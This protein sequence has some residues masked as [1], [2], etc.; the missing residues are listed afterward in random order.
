MEGQ[1]VLSASEHY[2]EIDNYLKENKIKK[3]FLVCGNS[4]NSLRIYDYLKKLEERMG[5][6]YVR[7]SNF[8]PNPAYESVLEGVKLFCEEGCDLIMAVGGGSAIDVAK[9]IKLYSNM[10]QSVSFLEQK[11]SPNDVKLFAVPTTAGSGSEATRYAVI[12]SNGEKQ[13]IT[14]YSCVP[15]VVLLDPSVLRTLPEYQKKAAML[16]A[17]CHAIESF[18]SV[19]ATEESKYYAKQAL[20]LILK[21][22]DAYLKNEVSGNAGMLQAANL[23]GMAINITQ[24]TAGHAM[25]YKLTGLYG[26]AHGHAAALCV[27]KLWSYM[28]DATNQYHDLAERVCLQKVFLEIAQA[29]GCNTAKAA[30]VQFQNILSELELAIPDSKEEDYAILRESV[31]MT[32]LRN[33]PM[34]LNAEVIE[35]L[36]RQILKK[37]DFY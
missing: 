36:Y 25:C 8:K 34:E 7:Y 23:A 24:T 21:Y 32:R 16:D 35:N 30:A 14:D 4:I 13:S 27:A 9:C 20:R 12:Y 11:I 28:I 29:M 33:H 26:I 22:K 3:I 10:D 19:H 31:N 17:F 37:T 1:M 18:W 2:E 15:S 5:I 6:S